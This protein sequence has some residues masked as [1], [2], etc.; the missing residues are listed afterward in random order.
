MRKEAGWAYTP[1]RDSERRK[2]PGLE[3]NFSP[4]NNTIYNQMLSNL[5]PN[6]LDTLKKKDILFQTQRGGHIKREEGQLHD[7]S[8]SILPGWEALQTGK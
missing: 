3:L 6:G 7:I 4:G 1:R 5:Q 8:N 2:S